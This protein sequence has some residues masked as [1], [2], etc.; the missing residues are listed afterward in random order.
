M[1]EDDFRQSQRLFRQAGFHVEKAQFD[2]KTF[3]SWWVELSRNGLPRQQVV[4]DGRDRWLIVQAFA[5]S[6]SWMDKWVGRKKA[7][8]TAVAALAQ[9]EVPVTREWGG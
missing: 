5:S 1:T 2:E 4:W 8:Q 9:L 3:G 6:G 7:E